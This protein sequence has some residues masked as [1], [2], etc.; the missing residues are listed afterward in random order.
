MTLCIQIRHVAAI[1]EL[2]VAKG[3]GQQT[4]RGIFLLKIGRWN[5]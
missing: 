1:G 2:E 3:L 5:I 4:D